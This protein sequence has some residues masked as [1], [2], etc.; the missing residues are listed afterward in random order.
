MKSYKLE[1]EIADGLMYSYYSCSSYTDYLKA[2][3]KEIKNNTDYSNVNTAIDYIDKAIC[4]E[5]HGMSE[6][7][8]S[9]IKK[10]FL[11]IPRILLNIPILE[12]TNYRFYFIIIALITFH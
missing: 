1:E 3:F 7:A 10:V 12:Q 6:T 8:L 2:G 11:H 4:Y 5:E 9:E